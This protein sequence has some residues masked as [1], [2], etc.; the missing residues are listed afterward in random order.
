MKD[1]GKDVITRVRFTVPADVTFRED[2][3]SRVENHLVEV[4]LGFVDKNLSD[5]EE[6]DSITVKLARQR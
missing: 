4:T 5:T 6:A 2:G 3:E 1:D